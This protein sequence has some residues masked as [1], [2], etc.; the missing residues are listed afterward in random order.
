MVDR[1]ESLF[2]NTQILAVHTIHVMARGA[3]VSR[4]MTIIGARVDDMWEMGFFLKIEFNAW[5][6]SSHSSL[7]L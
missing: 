2:I 4:N 7:S 5:L 3:R 6:I 1:L